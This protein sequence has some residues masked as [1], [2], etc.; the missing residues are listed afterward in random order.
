LDFARAPKKKSTRFG[1]AIII[2]KKEV[3]PWRGA[4]GRPARREGRA[5][6]EEGG[7]EVVGR[8]GGGREEVGM[9][10]GGG[11]TGRRPVL[12]RVTVVRMGALGN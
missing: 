3:A 7:R 9:E 10:G 11:G 6:M 1:V 12:V 8:E 5:V 2:P 4:R